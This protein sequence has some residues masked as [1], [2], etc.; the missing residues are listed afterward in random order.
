MQ[1]GLAA[2]FGGRAQ[3]E[4]GFDALGSGALSLSSVD[5]ND[6]GPASTG[7][8]FAP[9]PEP[10]AITI[11]PSPKPAAKPGKAA[12]QPLD[13]FAPP[14]AE[15]AEAKVELAVD[16][17]EHRAKKMS[18]P[19]VGVPVAAPPGQSQPLSVANT[20]AMR[21]SNPSMQPPIPASSELAAEMPR[22]RFAA[23]VVLSILIGFVPAHFVAATR[24]GTAF[25]KIDAT[26][27]ATQT[28]VEDED[29]YRALD[30]FREAQ[31]AKKKSERNTI[32]WQSMLIWA[33][34]GAGVA[35]VYFR[36]IPWAAKTA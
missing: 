27:T 36:R 32:A 31:L 4:S 3:S 14:D 22:G 21:R 6:E 25:N 18:T 9:P 12:S 2:A 30:G 20:P 10:V 5:G 24:E 23:G 19:P 15:E 11:A 28:S 1:S 34:V 8:A 16:E 26:V 13:L 29:G 17:I 33:V 7:G 35:Y